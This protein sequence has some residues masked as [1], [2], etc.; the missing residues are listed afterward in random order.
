M[1]QMFYAI[2]TLEVASNLA[3]KVGSGERDCLPVLLSIYLLVRW[4]LRREGERERE[5]II[6]INSHELTKQAFSIQ[7]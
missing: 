4:L 7:L 6:N 3:E 1:M 5:S 2:E